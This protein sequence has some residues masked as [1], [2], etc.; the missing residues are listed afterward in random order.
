M[1]IILKNND[2]NTHRRLALFEGDKNREIVSELVQ[3]KSIVA[4]K[5]AVTES[6]LDN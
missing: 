1:K 2:Y 3:F 6:V 5:S 4:G